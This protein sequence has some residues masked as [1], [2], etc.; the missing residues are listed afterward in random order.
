MFRAFLGIF[1]SLGGIINKL[2]GRAERHE[3]RAAGRNE[4]RLA[5]HDEVRDAET[6]MGNVE[7][8]GRDDLLDRLRGNGDI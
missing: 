1:S 2:L 3:Y 4:E 6:R 7:R 8:P 5:Q